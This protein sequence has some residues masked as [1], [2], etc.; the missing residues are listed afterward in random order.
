MGVTVEYLR[1]TLSRDSG[2]EADR[3]WS[4]IHACTRTIESTRALG[5]SKLPLSNCHKHGKGAKV[6]D[7]CQRSA[8]KV[9]GRAQRWRLESLEGGAA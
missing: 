4:L 3:L 2:R 8:P 7:P 1:I 6:L 9:C 5:L